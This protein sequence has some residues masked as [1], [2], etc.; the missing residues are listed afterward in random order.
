[1]GLFEGATLTIQALGSKRLSNFGLSRDSSLVKLTN[2]L[3]IWE[4]FT[5]IALCQLPESPQ[6]TSVKTYRAHDLGLRTLLTGV[7]IRRRRC[8]GIAHSL[9]PH[10]ELNSAPVS[11][12]PVLHASSTQVLL[13]RMSQVQT[14][15]F[16]HLHRITSAFTDWYVKPW[17][18]TD[19]T[20]SIRF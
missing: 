4:S 15:W 18:R 7:M 12:H 19:A 1:M 20:E 3:K 6:A 16:N 17:K 11:H 8:W 2:V 14:T 10:S 9:S 5:R 13:V